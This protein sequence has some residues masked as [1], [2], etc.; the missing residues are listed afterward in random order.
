MG[1]SAPRAAQLAVKQQGTCPAV[2]LQPLRRWAYAVAVPTIPAD[3]SERAMSNL[4]DTQLQTLRQLLSE[5]EV[6]LRSEVRAARQAAAERAPT[7]QV[8]DL[9][10]EGEERYR[11]GIEHVE[12]QRDLQ[13]LDDI[14][15]ALGRL[16][17]GSYGEC[18]A[19]GLPIAFERLNAQPSAKRCVAC[20]TVYEKTHPSAP[21]YSA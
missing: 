19:C 3:P 1:G 4:D 12:M 21:R 16:A 7:R 11:T 20:Q 10:E 14:D 9:G 15:A 8:E 5:R 2:Q 18:I 13:E 6:E 17:D